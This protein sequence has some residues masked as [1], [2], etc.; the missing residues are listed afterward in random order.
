[1]RKYLFKKANYF[2]KNKLIKSLLETDYSITLK[3]RNDE[4]VIKYRNHQIIWICSCQHYVKANRIC[5]H[6]IAAFA[7][8]SIKW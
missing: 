5:S 6:V 4:V 3:V 2:I 1:M 8:L 7:Y